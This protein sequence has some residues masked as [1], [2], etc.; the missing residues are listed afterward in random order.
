MTKRNLSIIGIIFIF[1][2]IITAIFWNLYRHQSFNTER[3]LDAVP[4]NSPMVLRINSANNLIGNLRDKINYRKELETFES[5]SSVF[6][7]LNFADTASLFSSG[8][9]SDLLKFPVYISFH[10]IGKNSFEWS[11]HFAVQNQAHQNEL[12]SWI[13]RHQSNQ[14]IYT[15]FSIYQ[16]SFSH[17]KESNIFATLQNGVL[18]VSPSPLMVEASIRQQQTGKSLRSNDQFVKLNKTTNPGAI[19][20]LFINFSILPEFLEPF[21]SSDSKNNASFF[22]QISSWGAIDLQLK[23]DRLTLNG[24]LSD[25]ESSKFIS[26]FE[27]VKSRKPTLAE[28]LPSDIKLFL[29]YNFS[30]NIRF[31][32]N[33]KRHISHSENPD[34]FETFNQQFKN[35]T[36]QHFIDA[37]FNLVDG[38][39]AMA[40]SNLNASN[41]KE[42]RFLIF[43]TKGQATS[44]PK[45]KEMQ[46]YFG[47][48]SAPV[49]RYKVDEST[50]FPIYR[51][52][53]KQLVK[54]V[55]GHL[56]P[57]TPLQYF[58]FYRNYLIFGDSQKSLQSFLYNNV[59]NRTLQSH[60]YFSSF[61]ENFAYEEN[62]FLFA[63]I[64]HLYS[65]I[66]PHL[67]PEK[68]HPTKEQNRELFNF[69]GAGFQLSHSAGLNYITACADYT[70]HR[71]KEPRTIW[72]SRLDSTVIM[73]PALV[74]NHY[75]RE[76]EIMVQDQANN[77][78][79]INNMGRILW[80]KPL[81]GP[82]KSEIFQ[83]DYY[84]NKKLQYLFNTE[85]KLY[86]LDRNGNHV[87][88]FPYTL[89]SKATNGL[90]VFDYDNTRN[91]RIF[92]ALNDRKIY[93][94]DK[95]GARIPGWNIPQT[96]GIVRQPVQFF[97][98]SGKDYIVF[99]DQYR[100]YILDRRGNTRI[101]PNKVFIRNNLSPFYLEYP[102]SDKSALITTASDGSLAKIML[103]TGKTILR[104][105]TKVE[106]SEHYFT[107]LHENNPQYILVTPNQLHIYNTSLRSVVNK[108]FDQPIKVFADIYKF[109]SSDFKIGLVSETNRKIYLFNN[110]ATL[111]KGFPLKG[112]TRFS[113]G[114]LK[115]SAYR[116]NLITGGEN[117]FIYNYRVE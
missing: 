51:G 42:G 109:S 72:Q 13:D 71:D 83:I 101:T 81:D 61:M 62:L 93:L 41:P 60:P 85:K 18:T 53:P 97:R 7:F 40:F 69:Y 96:E 110:D 9:V 34:N 59:L 19:G 86:L 107:L 38:E 78:Y 27:G 80:K 12:K 46:E 44:L 14:R 54:Q 89:P 117:N 65:F 24:F 11:L 98:N 55:L 20:S 6:Q 39:F 36:G 77:L 104:S 21:F 10:K 26:L 22:G 16:I 113:I 29:S 64:P 17:S 92:L 5:L 103:P 57:D 32:K 100:N 90:S 108:A 67:N 56:F 45:L 52:F 105:E 8:A 25:S 111:Y 48:A 76:K 88:R 50:S 79:L 49:A 112:T 87:A 84:R 58:S 95:S 1:L 74:E 73:K 68:F 91:Y 35:A 115:S 66:G 28:V 70:P 63:E 30:D 2:V 47:I 31:I 82:I 116:F 94:F 3:T 75:T 114:F 37:F 106:N 99:S 15:G 43:R 102:N 23:K 4:A 33:L